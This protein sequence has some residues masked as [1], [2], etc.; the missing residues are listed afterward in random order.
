MEE[1]KEEKEENTKES[2]DWFSTLM[3]PGVRAPNTKM[4]EYRL[5]VVDL[6]EFKGDKMQL[7]RSQAER[8][9]S[10][11]SQIAEK[12][13]PGLEYQ[14]DE[15]DVISERKLIVYTKDKLRSSQMLFMGNFGAVEL[16]IYTDKELESNARAALN[17]LLFSS[18]A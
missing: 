7:I 6:T 8:A 12:E 18:D 15:S 1:K 17:D 9:K 14:F 11:F 13:F 5:F 10:I 3:A 4:A 16:Y 2:T